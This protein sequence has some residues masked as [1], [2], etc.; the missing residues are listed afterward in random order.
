[1]LATLFNALK[2]VVNPSE[3]SANRRR[4]KRYRHKLPLLVQPLDDDYMET[5]D[6]FWTTSRDFSRNGIGFN[7]HKTLECRFVNI[8]IPDHSFSGIAEVR[9]FTQ[10]SI[11]NGMYIIGAEFMD[12]FDIA[13]C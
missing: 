6:P 2:F 11:D 7:W 12:E 8:S 1:M 13:I 4:L 9:H 5:G 3:R 10:L